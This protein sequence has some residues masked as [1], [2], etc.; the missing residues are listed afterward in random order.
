M[1]K[2]L[3]LCLLSLA[4]PLA[5][6]SNDTAFFEA[7]I[8]PVL[9]SKC[10]DCHSAGAKK[11]KANLLLDT[12]EGIRKGGDSGPAVVPG[13]ASA[14]LLMKAI[15]W[16]DKDMQMPPKQQLSAEVIADLEQWIASGAVDPREGKV[17]SSLKM[18]AEEAKTFWSF[19]PV[20]APALPEVNDK[21]W[22]WTDMDR[23]VRAAQEAKGTLPVGEADRA[24]LVR[25][26]YFDMIGLPPTP[27]Q[28]TAFVNDPDTNVL[29]KT[30]D[31]LLKSPQF[32]ER[33]GRHWL[34]I[35]RYAESTGKERN[36]PFPEAWRYRDYVIDSFNDDKPY[37][38]FVREQIAG[39]LLLVHSAKER[40]DH[41]IATAFLAL[42]PKSVA[43]KDT[44]LFKNDL[45]DEQIDVVTRGFM[46][47]TVS[48]ARCHDHKFDPFSMND[49]YAMAGIFHSSYT[50]F[51][52]NGPKVRNPSALLPLIA[53]NTP[54]ELLQNTL[55]P[56]RPE[57]VSMR[58]A[59]PSKSKAKG[60]K[61]K[62]QGQ[63]VVTLTLP[64][65]VKTEGRA[66]G[67]RE[68]RVEDSPVYARGE[69]DEPGA[70]V[71]RG[72]VPAIHVPN[73][74]A[75]PSE[76]S[77][78]AQL[79]EWVTSKD[80]PLTAR[81]AV[82]RVWAQLFGAGI[83]TTPDNFGKMGVRPT[84][85]P[86]LD[87]LAAQFM[88]DGW[89]MKKLI[90]SIVL[91]RTYQLASSRD[92]KNQT[93]DPD[94]TTLWHATQRRLD[95]EAIRDAV[96]QITGSLDL[97]RP[98][99]S[100]VATMPDVDLAKSA[101]YAK[102]TDEQS[103]RSVYLPI[104]RSRVPEMLETFDFAEPSLLAASRD[105]TN[106]PPQALFM[107]NSDFIDQQ[108]N[109][110]A[111]I[112]MKARMDDRERVNALYWRMLCRPATNAELKRATDFLQHLGKLGGAAE[113][114]YT[115]LCQAVFA[116]AEFRFIK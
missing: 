78:R 107:L 44:A 8:R 93:L 101:Q 54:V 51:G 5:F 83:V 85:Q 50:A 24:T 73:T 100:V 3:S 46:G 22:A 111:H 11:V 88:S 20:H 65:E 32:G 53:E 61:Y 13:D 94:N 92:G 36:F 18:T 90:R 103:V 42:G 95:A 45:I 99:G 87:Y 102:L 97:H 110:A 49:Y 26:V 69:P 80:N 70:T 116:S 72:F 47:L 30:V 112:L 109:A 38:Q 60:K 82:N 79:A 67:V 106:V 58:P 89:S 12:R 76:Q 33:W 9:V 37:D 66:M 16:E 81:V 91:S 4:S 63:P 62:N 41:I 25:R 23:F 34:D 2:L 105:T 14:S 48:C 21:S 59:R 10:Y 104:V 39:D 108:S 68:G 6:A 52:I 31:Q 86:L 115:A 71:Q 114:G 75:I 98:S 28:T 1:P 55:E 17:A 96:L 57:G 19:Q 7:K 74:P 27:Q 15:R 64:S 35:A 40:N 43:E 77:G 29:E 113:R 56:D 84:N